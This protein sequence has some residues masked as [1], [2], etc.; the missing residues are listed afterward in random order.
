M[1]R[2]C[3]TVPLSLMRQASV[4]WDIDWGGQ[5]A[6]ETL[7]AVSQVVV[8]G[9]PRFVGAPSL[10]FGRALHGLWRAH[11]WAAQGQAGLFRVPMYDPA[12]LNISE[13]SA[14]S[15][16]M[17]S[18]TTFSNG[19]TFSTGAGWAYWPQLSVVT[20]GGPGRARIKVSVPASYLLPKVGQIMSHDDWP[21]GV[22]GV[23]DNGDGTAWL[24]VERLAKSV[25]T[26]DLVNV[27]GIGRFEL[28][29]GMSGRA[30]YGPDGV[31]KPK[32]ALREVLNRG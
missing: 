6:G 28:T 17:A 18:G 4:D 32:L 25:A 23:S 19:E 13:L 11:R 20:G 14:L 7:T 22:T 15:G 30:G 29:D 10:V 24:T 16:A 12:I 1:R 27:I 21:F 3:V 8:N 5:A 2:A 31:I 26:G 9:F